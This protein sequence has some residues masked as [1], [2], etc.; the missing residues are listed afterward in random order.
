[1][2]TGFGAMKGFLV[3]RKALRS[4]NDV[5]NF[6]SLAVTGLGL[7]PPAG[8]QGWSLRTGRLGVLLISESSGLEGLCMNKLIPFIE[9]FEFEWKGLT[10]IWGQGK[11]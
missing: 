11:R 9:L 5:I 7:R 1:M 6:E 10:W 8:S 2:R 4:G 3:L